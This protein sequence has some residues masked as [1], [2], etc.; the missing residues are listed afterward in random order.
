MDEAEEYVKKRLLIVGT[1][2]IATSTSKL[3]RDKFSEFSPEIC[4]LE[5]DSNRMQALMSV[6]EEKRGPSL[7]DTKKLGFK[8]YLF[9]KIGGIIQKRLGES[10]GSTPG[11]DM[12]AA[13]MEAKR[14]EIP[15]F[16]IDRNLE[17][18]LKEFSRRF[19]LREASRMAWDLISGILFKRGMI[20]QDVQL[21]LEKVPED[22]VVKRAVE[23]IKKRYPSLYEVLVEDRNRIM[24]SR[25]VEIMRSNPGKKVIAVLGAGHKEGVMKLV[26]ERRREI[27]EAYKNLKEEKGN[28]G[29]SFTYS[30]S[31]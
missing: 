20:A 30:F 11:V 10:I 2:H 7:S 29:K 17:I 19:T 25:I 27:Y 14:R 13:I 5:L 8:G 18:T 23:E 15:I 24:A 9:A 26:L 28:L 16:L 12:K 22:E 1:S 3:I 6:L 31:I 4:A 21:D